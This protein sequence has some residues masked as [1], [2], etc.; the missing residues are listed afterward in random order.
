MLR[1]LATPLSTARLLSELAKH[2]HLM[3]MLQVQPGLPCRLHRPWLSVNMDRQRTLESLAWHYQVMSRQLPSTL[4][5]GY[6]SKSGV[7]LLTLTGK[8]EQQF[9]VRLCADAFMDKEEK[10]P[11]F[12]VTVKH[13][14]GGDD[15]YAMPV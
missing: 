10:R 11:S 1:S 4:I 7:T 6:L 12:S 15:L 14:A 5:N 2:P 3:Q 13:R 9:T 8:E